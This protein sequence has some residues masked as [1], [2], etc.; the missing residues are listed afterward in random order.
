MSRFDPLPDQPYAECISCGLTLAT[1]DDGREHMTATRPEAGQGASH[2]IR[3]TNQPRPDRIRSAVARVID[4]A[5]TDSL[6][7]I[8]RLVERDGATAEEV[9]EALRFYPDF[10]DAYAEWVTA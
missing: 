10:A 6:E 1:Q 9:T 3:I 8:D 7:D 2:R 5:I 4:D